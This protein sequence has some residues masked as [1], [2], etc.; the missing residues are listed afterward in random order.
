MGCVCS[1]EFAEVTL[2][3]RTVIVIRLRILTL[4][5]IFKHR[6]LCPHVSPTHIYQL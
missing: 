2:M 6:V 4:E 5:I 3:Q 1:G